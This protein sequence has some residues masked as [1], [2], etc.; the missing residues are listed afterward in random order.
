M[1]LPTSLSV[2]LSALAGAIA[3]IS[4]QIPIGNTLHI[5]IAGSLTFLAGLGIHPQETTS[6]TPAS[7]LPAALAQLATEAQ[8]N[9]VKNGPDGVQSA[10]LPFSGAPAA[11]PAVPAPP[12]PGA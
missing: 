4:T 5:L 6:T 11:T 3:V 10:A 7:N 2:L 12:A 8:N 9:V 1:K